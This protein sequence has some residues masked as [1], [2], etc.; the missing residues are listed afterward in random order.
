M[1][2]V[3]GPYPSGRWDSA[4]GYKQEFQGRGQP[5]PPDDIG[6]NKD[7][8]HALDKLMVNPSLVRGDGHSCEPQGRDH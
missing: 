3:A 7:L 6:G 5:R 8:V 2:S 4:H 1:D